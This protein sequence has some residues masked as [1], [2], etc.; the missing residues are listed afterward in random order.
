LQVGA[1]FCNDSP[2]D[3][4]NLK[5]NAAVDAGGKVNP[6]PIGSF[7]VFTW[8]IVNT[9]YWAGIHTVCDAFAHIRHNCM[10]HW[11]FSLVR[12]QKWSRPNQLL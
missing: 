7:S 3:W 12:A 2:F 8:A 6:I 11:L 1:F 4:T 10:S 5:A 9:G